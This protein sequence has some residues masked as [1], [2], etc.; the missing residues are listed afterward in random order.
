ADRSRILAMSGP[1]R[2]LPQLSKNWNLVAVHKSQVRQLNS[3]FGG[4]F[5]AAGFADIFH[6]ADDALAAAGYYPAVHDK[7]LIERGGE[8]ISDLVSIRGEEVVRTDHQ[9][10]SC[11]NSQ[12]ARNGL[13]RGRR[14]GWILGA[15]CG[16]PS[17]PRRRCVGVLA[18][19]GGR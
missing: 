12:R 9:D 17:L 2:A 14:R 11:G 18:G 13:G 7:G 4:A 3:Q 16:G 8:L 19:V 5:D 6:F 10:G 15:L 1:T